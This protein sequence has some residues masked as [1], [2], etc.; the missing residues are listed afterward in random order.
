MGYTL[1]QIAVILA[2]ADRTMYKIGAIAYDDMF[3][4]LDESL[5]YDRDIIYIYKV[6]VEYAD[7]FYVGTEKLDTVVERL[8]AKVAVYDFGQLTPIYSDSTIVT[9][10]VPV[11]A[12]LDDLSDVT[13]TNVQNNQTLRYSSSLG[14]WVNVGPGAATRNRQQ[15]TATLNQTVFVTSFQFESGLLDVYLNGV[16]LS[17]PSYTTFGNYTITLADGSLADDIVEVVAYT[18]ETSFIDLSGY[19]PTSRTLTINGVTYDLSANRSWTVTAGLSSVGLSMPSGFTVSN[20]PLTTNGT[21]AVG[22]AS[23]YSIPTTASQATWNTAYNDSIVSAAVTGTS[24]KTLTLN[25][26]DGGTVTASWSD[27]DT[28]LTSVGLSMPSAFAVS[29]SPLTSN[30]TLAVTGAGTSAQYV[31][32]DGQLANFPTNGGGGSSVNYY[33]NGSVSQGTFGGDTYYEMSKTP[34]IGAGTNF[35]RTN[36]QGNGYIASFITDAGDPALL[37]IPGGNWN[38]EFYFQASSGGGNPSFYAELYKVSSANVFTL[39][40]SGS[41]NPEGITQG[42]V[43]DQYFTSIPVPQTALLATD[44]IAIRIFVTPS[45]RTITLHTENSNLC[46]VLTTFSTGLNALNGLTAQVQYFATGTSGTDF[47]ISSATDT[48]TFNLPIASGTN[49]GKLSN[50]DWTTFNNKVGGTGVSGQ[51]AYWNGT[52][53]QTGSNNLFWD[54][55]NGYLG[56]KRTNPIVEIDVV[57]S[58]RA[59][60]TVFNSTTQTNNI[61]TNGQ[62]LAIK[63]VTNTYATMFQST[64][65]FVIQNGGTF[66]DAGYKLD[67]VG[68]STPIA[69]F[70]G[71]TNAYI[72]I[73]DG[74]VNSRIQNSGG[75]LIGTT[76]SHDLI[77]RTNSVSRLTITAA[78]NVGIGTTTPATKLEV[79]GASGIQIRNGAT[80][81]FS[82]QQANTN[83]WAWTGLTAGSTYIIQ[84]ANLLVGTTTDSGYK[85]DVNGTARVSGATG[86]ILTLNSTNGTGYSAIKIDASGVEK[87]LIGFGT[88]LTSDAGVAIRTAA[89]TPFTIAIGGGVPTLTLASS[90]AATFSSSATATTFYVP[91]GGDFGWGDGSTFIDGDASNQ[92][93]RFIINSSE[94]ARFNPSGNLLLGSTS[95]NGNRLQ[96]SG[97]GS[98]TNIITLNTSAADTVSLIVNGNTGSGVRQRFIN[99]ASSGAY[100]WQIGTSI[101][102]VNQFEIIPSTAI[103]GTTFTTPVFKILATGAATFSSSVTAT[104]FIKSGGTSSQYLMADGSVTTGGGG[105]VDELQVALICQV[106]G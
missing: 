4:Q 21:I 84:N 20:S 70:T 87:G 44:R 88:Y 78:G 11:G 104:S 6:A 26:Q 19:V 72:D 57:G 95:D 2:K 40:A 71:T 100:N 31:R 30:G 34:I 5:D 48:H 67:I 37:N 53:S 1:P 47:A 15:F 90:G 80:D 10:V 14:Q 59:S 83:S 101:T 13:I 54:A 89:S 74:T 46:E 79:V 66:T 55:A 32:G 36:A 41:T 60:A 7:N 23:G 102:A 98:F 77:L 65:N 64:G 103:D 52:N 9:Q 35:T 42:T 68:S 39:I 33:L 81:G 76:T 97:A 22:L 38:V 45:G 106:F 99:Q 93:I 69:R 3:N 85:L 27:I 17:P 25:Q 29:N 12:A 8:G 63:G 75:L 82:F 28:G 56:V 96:V 58:I 50:T 49:T 51:V 92:F 24:T 91:N 18:P 105:S 62:N 94:R 73:T 43:V 86:T 16:K 61:Q